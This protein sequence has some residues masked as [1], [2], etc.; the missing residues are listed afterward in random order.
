MQNY[1]DLKAK[2]NKNRGSLLCE[3]F[4]EMNNLRIKQFR[5]AVLGLPA[6]LFM[7]MQWYLAS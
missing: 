6:S 4:Y 1:S 5:T 7:D 2:T 3:D